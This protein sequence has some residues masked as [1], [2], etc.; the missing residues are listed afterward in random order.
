MKT[1]TGTALA[2]ALL[3]AFTLWAPALAV[4]DDALD[5]N[6]RQR[7]QFERERVEDL[8]ER[9]RDQTREHRQIMRERIDRIDQDAR[10]RNDRLRE[11]SQRPFAAP[12]SVKEH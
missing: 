11:Q 6:V 10:Q 12:G 3:A 8:R 5:D 7:Q 1:I 9:T 4:A 2:A